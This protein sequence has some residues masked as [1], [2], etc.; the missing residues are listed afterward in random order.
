MAAPYDVIVVGGG[1]GGGMAANALGQAGCRVLVLERARLPRYKACAGG[2][3][4][5]IFSTLPPAC[6]QAIECQVRHVRLAFPGEGELSYDI[7]GAPIAMVS[8]LRFD[9]A[10]LTSARADIHDG[11]GAAVVEQTGEGVRVRSTRGEVY[12]AGHLIGADGA[13][14]LVARSARLQPHQ[15]IGPALEAE[16]E[17]GEELM[18]RYGNASLFLIG[19]VPGGYAWVFPKRVT[20]SFGIGAYKG[21]GKALRDA[22]LQCAASLGIPA[23]CVRLRGHGLPVYRPRAAISR[24]RILLVGDAAALMDPLSGEG[25]RYA[26]RSGRLAAEAIVSGRVRDYSRWVHRDIGR[27]LSAGLHLATLF[28]AA[29]RLCFRLGARNPTVVAGL[30]R[31]L[32]GEVNYG[33]LIARVPGYLWRRLWRR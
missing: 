3:P 29:P 9:Y 7:H 28:Y 1:P 8:R 6:S 27:H 17:A 5:Q 16:V 20:L 13:F 23:E 21:T 32:A 25:V 30:M 33:D 2:V 24:G 18:A 22:L 12:T 11:E 10:L 14:S 15:G 26:L 19:V 4:S 31:M